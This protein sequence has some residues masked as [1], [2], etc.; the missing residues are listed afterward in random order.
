MEIYFPARQTLETNQRI[1]NICYWLSGNLGEMVRRSL[2][3]F[4]HHFLVS[5]Y[6]IEQ[7]VRYITLWITLGMYSLW[8]YLSYSLDVGHVLSDSMDQSPC[9]A[10]S[11]SVSQILH[12]FLL[13]IRACHWSLYC[14]R[15]IQ[16]TSHPISLRFNLIL[17]SSLHLGLSNGLVTSC[18]LTHFV[19]IS[20]WTLI[21]NINVFLRKVI[22]NR[23]DTG[24]CVVSLLN[25][26]HIEE[27]FK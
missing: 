27:C 11:H 15:Q 8:C 1:H 7:M 4:L 24:L 9:E 3:N 21:V 18:F 10:N 14:V 22:N 20:F 26:Y 23:Y 16:S 2:T 19:S 6:L 17:S 13:F 5:G 25:M 12:L